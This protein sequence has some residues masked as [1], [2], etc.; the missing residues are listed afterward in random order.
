M[1]NAKQWLDLTHN[2][3]MSL[4][5]A[6]THAMIERMNLD[7]SNMKVIHVAGS[8]GKGTA[9]SLMAASLTLSGV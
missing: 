2:N 4:G 8:N 6:N 7:F 9:C 1:P 3:G 5:L